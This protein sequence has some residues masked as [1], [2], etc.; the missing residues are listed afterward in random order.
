MTSDERR[1]PRFTRTDDLQVIRSCGNA[2][3]GLIS[4]RFRRELIAAAWNGDLVTHAPCSRSKTVGD[5]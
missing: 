1:R 5:W 4:L 2:S 3:E